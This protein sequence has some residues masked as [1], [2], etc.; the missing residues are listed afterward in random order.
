[1]PSYRPRYFRAKRADDGTTG[2]NMKSGVPTRIGKS[3]YVMRLIKLRT[4]RACCN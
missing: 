2:G 4:D 1:M 3:P